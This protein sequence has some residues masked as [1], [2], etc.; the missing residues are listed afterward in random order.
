MAT[1]GRARVLGFGGGDRRTGADFLEIGIQ[2]AGLAA[3]SQGLGLRS[4]R[5]FRAGF[6]H[7]MRLEGQDP[8][9]MVRAG[10]P[11]AARLH[12]RGTSPALALGQAADGE[13]RC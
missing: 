1:A 8:L 3:E 13:G 7:P 2:G 6:I 11:T 5:P 12:C 9:P 4:A 10:V